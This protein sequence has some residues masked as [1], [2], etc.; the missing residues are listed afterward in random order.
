MTRRNFDWGNT[1]PL[2]AS[3]SGSPSFRFTDTLSSDYGLISRHPRLLS[4]LAVDN[5]ER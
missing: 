4:R 5:G 3:H 2:S 1:T